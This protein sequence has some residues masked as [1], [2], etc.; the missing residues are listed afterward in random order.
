MKTRLC[1]VNRTKGKALLISWWRPLL[2]LLLLWSHLAAGALGQSKQWDK[3]YGGDISDYGTSLQQTKDGG[4]ILGGYSFSGV[5][6]DKTGAS[7][8]S[9]DYWVVKL[10]AAGNKQWDKTYGGDGF[11]Y[12]SSLDQT[13]DGGYILGG[14]SASGISGDKT[15]SS[16]GVED[17][18]VVKLDAAGNKQWDRTYGGDAYDYCGSVQQTRDGGYILGG[19]SSSGLSGDKTDRGHGG[20][21]YWVVK[22]NA[23]GDMIWDKTYGGTSDDIGISLQ[24]TEDGGYVLGGYSD[25]GIGGDKTGDSRGNFDYWV[26]KLDAAG[27]YEWDRTCGGAFTDYGTSIRQT[28]DGG[29]LLGGY[30]FSGS[31]GDKTEA[32]RGN[33]DYWVV[34]LDAAGNKQWDKTYGG[35]E[36]DYFTS[37]AQTRDEGYILG[38]HSAS[39]SSGDKTED[40]QGEADFWIVKLDAA[41]NKQWEKTLG[42]NNID[43]LSALQQTQDGGYVLGGYSISDKS[44]DKTQDSRGNADYWVVKL[45]AEIAPPRITAFSPTKGLPGTRVTLTG[46]HLATTRAVLF[47]GQQASFEVISDSAV[48]ATVPVG[49]TSGNITV[50]T[51]GGQATSS[52]AFTVLQPEI[53]L[54]TPV[55]GEVGARVYLV[56]NRLATARDVYFNGVRSPRVKVYLDWVLSAVVPEGATTGKIQVV[57]QGGGTA[58]TDSDFF[59]RPA[60]VK[61]APALA[62]AETPAGTTR[63][64]KIAAVRVVAYPNPFREQVSFSFTLAQP[65]PVVVKVYDMLGREVSLLYQDEAQAGQAYRLEWRPPAGL[66][67]GLYLIRLQAPGQDIRKKVVL[68]R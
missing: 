12:L 24:Q 38:G 66:P 47:N 16:R 43:F 53:V 6:G 50:E 35:N 39:G 10:D 60:A 27:N 13:R 8:G 49:A 2:V 48:K 40:S 41:G 21:D 62:R 45:A 64:G 1:Q 5:S 32:N 54:F 22:L 11:D 3:T 52:T 28:K 7:R 18:W 33:A 68:A 34:K 65:Q 25:S 26:V 59:V 55:Q 36:L 58:T 19:R 44:G 57:L 4:Y 46:R 17:Y 51:A 42:G 29:Y 30:S 23:A 63:S 61:A 14:R 37:L 56:G 67:G 15:E 31:S 9:F 20:A